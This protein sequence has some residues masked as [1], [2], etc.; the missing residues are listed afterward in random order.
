V[1]SADPLKLALA[2]S[3]AQRVW[4]PLAS[5]GRWPGA[6]RDGLVYQPFRPLG[7]AGLRPMVVVGVASSEGVAR[8]I[9]RRTGRPR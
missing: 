8:T 7:V 3:R 5:S 6:D 1:A 4:R 9:I 2:R